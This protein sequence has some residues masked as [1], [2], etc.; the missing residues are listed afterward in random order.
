MTVLTVIVP[1]LIPVHYEHTSSCCLLTCCQWLVNPCKVGIAPSGL[2]PAVINPDWLGVVAEADKQSNEQSS[3]LRCCWIYR[4]SPHLPSPTPLPLKFIL[5]H[6]FSSSLCL[7]VVVWMIMGLCV[8]MRLFVFHLNVS[9]AVL[10]VL[11]EL[12]LGLWR[13][14]KAT[15]LS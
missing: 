1:P 13:K 2:C 10:Y 12:S 5:N 14:N 11:G 6:F 4:S 15:T 9:S 8:I 3:W 7:W